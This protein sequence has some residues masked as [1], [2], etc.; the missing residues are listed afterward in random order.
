MISF[1]KTSKL[2]LMTLAFSSCAISKRP[3]PQPAE[4]RHMGGMVE[5]KYV[6]DGIPSFHKTPEQVAVSIDTPA[7]YDIRDLTWP[8]DSVPHRKVGHLG[9]LRFEI[10]NNYLEYSGP[11]P[12]FTGFIAKVSSGNKV[13]YDNSLCE[14]HHLTMTR[15]TQ[16][17]KDRDGQGDRFFRRRDRLFPN[18]GNEY[19]VCGSGLPRIVWVCPKCSSQC[20]REFKKPRW[21][22]SLP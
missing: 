16:R 6:I 8:E 21:S 9:E 10:L 20:D 13:L 18:D 19:N 7:K 2:L 14:V 17:G 22:Q 3:I 5:K 11:Q 4:T 12:Y 1:V 15:N